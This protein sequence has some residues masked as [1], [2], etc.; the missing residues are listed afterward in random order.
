MSN[1][2]WLSW[3]LFE[4]I[5][6]AHLCLQIALFW[7][8]CMYLQ[9]I[10]NCAPWHIR[11]CEKITPITNI[12]VLAGFDLLPA[13]YTP[14]HLNVQL[15]SGI[16]ECH[17]CRSSTQPTYMPKWK[18]DF[19]NLRSY[20]LELSASKWFRCIIINNFKITRASDRDTLV[21]WMLHFGM[22]YIDSC[23]IV[24]VP[25]PYLQES[26]IQLQGF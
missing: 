23:V 26:P 16:H 20:E 21:A 11:L 25:W 5:E 22:I 7:S 4:L 17:T 19:L 3:F 8:C 6:K 12:H 9:H 15:T 24:G 13:Y 14:S 1:L 2:I 18:L 10:Q